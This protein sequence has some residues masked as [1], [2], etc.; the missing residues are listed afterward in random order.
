MAYVSYGIEAKAMLAQPTCH[1]TATASL[2][3]HTLEC[4]P[5]ER[6]PQRAAYSVQSTKGICQ[7]LCFE[8]GEITCSSVSLGPCETL[9]I[10]LV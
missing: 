5:L 9:R 7:V 2:P 8:M 6:L 1:S 3:F 10:E 4:C